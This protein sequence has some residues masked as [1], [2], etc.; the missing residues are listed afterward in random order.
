[1]VITYWIRTMSC[2]EWSTYIN[3]MNRFDVACVS[4]FFRGALFMRYARWSCKPSVEMFRGNRCCLTVSGAASFLVHL[5]CV[6]ATQQNK[7]EARLSC[8]RCSRK[9]TRHVSVYSRLSCTRNTRKQ[10]AGTWFQ[11]KPI[12]YIRAAWRIISA[13]NTIHSAFCFRTWPYI[14]HAASGR[15]SKHMLSLCPVELPDHSDLLRL[16]CMMIPQGRKDGATYHYAGLHPHRAAEQKSPS[17][18]V[19]VGKQ[20][21]KPHAHVTVCQNVCVWFGW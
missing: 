20:D 4:D 12:Y 18:P 19:R 13:N 21:R 9:V 15:C 10:V 3:I 8:R 17:N 14:Y 5:S 7:I 16:W 6:I 11:G 1:M 2:L